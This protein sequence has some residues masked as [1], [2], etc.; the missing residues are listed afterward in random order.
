[1][2]KP[3]SVLDNEMHKVLLD[4]E[5]RVDQLIS[6]RQPDLEI[7]NKQLKKNILEKKRTYRIVDFASRQT[8]E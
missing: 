2:L 7:I 4:F 5:I 8:T 1:M 3:E 6:A